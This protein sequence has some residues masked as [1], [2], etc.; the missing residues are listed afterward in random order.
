MTES[1][2]IDRRWLITAGL[3]AGSAS[4]SSSTMVMPDRR[5]GATG[6]ELPILGF[7]GSAFVE[8][9]ARFYRAPILP[10][11]ERLQLVRAAFDSGIRY[12]DTAPVYY[13]SEPLIG[14]ALADVR[15]E[16]F[17]ATKVESTRPEQVRPSVEGS[18]ARLQTDV[19]DCVQIH[20][21]P[22]I[23]NMT[24]PDAMRIHGELVKLRDEGLLR[25]IG[26]T[27]HTAF[28]KMHEMISS[29]GF[30]VVLLACGYF[31]KGWDTLLS[32]RM[33]ELRELCL[34]EA[35]RRGMGIVG[36]K[37]LGGWLCGHNADTY[38]PDAGGAE[39]AKLP[40]AAIRFALHDP[41]VTH[42]LV[43]L[44]VPSDLEEAVATVS[45]DLALTAD[46]RRRLAE[47]GTAV[48]GHPEIRGYEV[49]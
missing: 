21:L 3:A 14:K 11:G 8:R 16:V 6:V 40:A 1:R 22:G 26:L 2:G 29:G 34:A 30:D 41:R 17:Y 43:G 18:L 4:A 15:G 39:L 49:T 38:A 7:G 44:C 19:L 9:F 36:M 23:E 48:Y 20:G 31:H 37:A 46:D 12:F 27:G 45:G 28:D 35:H 42:L 5:L 32:H 13:E 25:F 24:V 10:E 47:F 33:L